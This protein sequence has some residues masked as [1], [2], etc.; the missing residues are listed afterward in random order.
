MTLTGT[1]R[2]ESLLV[3]DDN[4]LNR[5][6]LRRRLEEVGY[7]VTTIESGWA[8][9]E[10]LKHETYDLILLDIMMPEMDGFQVLG[11]LKKNEKMGRI[12]VMM[13][14]AVNDME[15][16][17]KCIGLGARDYVAKP[18]EASL[19]RSRV[20]RVLDKYPV[21]ERASLQ[22][23]AIRNDVRVLVVDDQ[24]LN[25]DL[26]ASQL[27]RLGYVTEQASSGAEAL[28]KLAQNK[29]DCVLLDIMM[30]DMDGFQVLDTIRAKEHLKLLPII[31]L[32]ALEDPETITKTMQRGAS[33][34]LT[35]PFHSVI[36]KTRIQ[37]ALALDNS[38]VERGALDKKNKVIANVKKAMLSNSLE[39]PVAADVGTSVLQMCLLP[40]VI[41]KDL[42]DVIKLDASLTTKL[43]SV[44]NSNFYK[45]VKKVETLTEAVTRLGLNETRRYA[46]SLS[47]KNAYK[48][49]L[50]A[51]AKVADKVWNHAVAVAQAAYEISHQFKVS[52]PDKLYTL[53][54]IHD[55]GMSVAL[56]VIDEAYVGDA[57]LTV[58][59]VNEIAGP[60]HADVGAYVTERWKLP[61]DY[62][63]AIRKHHHDDLSKATLDLSVLVLAHACAH[64]L[65]ASANEADASPEMIKAIKS[66]LNMPDEKW[67][68]LC[69]DVKAKVENIKSLA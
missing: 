38:A 67:T 52:D 18:F 22:V 19:L 30:P 6:L 29:Y 7:L 4:D 31:M 24:V 3:V 37:N 58:E 16:V 17:V 23:G 32:S 49:G 25:R 66:Q 13:V 54:L 68:L 10:R 65:G 69:A 40:H 28:H 11:E 15:H 26:V 21:S 20:A 42:T 64:E 44:A 8:A 61:E 33:D 46:L 2:S 48:G 60:V 50:G 27:Q 35:K 14:T 36:L 62:S 51:T 41:V 63:L 1:T 45:G 56:R 9:L 5:E 53:G 12:P 55:V 39:L 59:L 34:Y 43:L 57:Q 47:S